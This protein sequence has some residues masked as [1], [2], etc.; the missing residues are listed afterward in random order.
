[1]NGL[2]P[3]R[4][5]FDFELPIRHR[6]EPPG[7][8]GDIGEWDEQYRLP[9]LCRLDG[10]QPFAAVYA[11][12]N[13]EGLYVA[14]QVTGKRRRLTCNPETFWK[15]DHLRIC[16]DTR[17]ARTVKRATRFCQQF[18]LLPSGGGSQGN[19]PVGGSHKIQRA[20]EDAPTYPAGRIPVGARV[21]RSG[22]TLD[23]HLPADCLA[24]FDPVENPRI[25][26]YYMLEDLELGQQCLTVGDDLYWYVDP[27]TW[28]TA[29]LVR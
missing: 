1:M 20:R 5:L 22:Y 4:F 17:D 27:S 29:V 3:T 26:F 12:W 16:T 7:L 13:E 14:V 21:S 8:I 24:G 25:G 19:H 6:P 2:V 28:A 9:D 10:Q 23:A 11:A 18:Y 15:C